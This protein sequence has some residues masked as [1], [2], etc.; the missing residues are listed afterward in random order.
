M[1]CKNCGCSLDEGV[2]FCKKCG[3]R[4]E[5]EEVS[6]DVKPEPVTVPNKAESNDPF[7]KFQPNYSAPENNYGAP[8]QQNNFNAPNYQEP[9]PQII[10]NQ[11]PQNQYSPQYRPIS[12]WG[13]FGYNLLFSIPLVGFICLIIFSL[14]SD[15]INRRNYARSFWCWFA[16]ALILGAVFGVLVL[17]TGGDLL[18]EI[19]YYF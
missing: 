10:L 7:P 3:T 17:I 14:S 15:N 19:A 16:L 18:D 4:V 1:F 2:K 13:Y 11:I 5:Y 6:Y 9:Q 8:A 12:A